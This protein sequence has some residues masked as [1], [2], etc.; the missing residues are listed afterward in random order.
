MLIRNFLKPKRIILGF[1]CI[2]LLTCCKNNSKMSDYNPLLEDFN[3][4]YQTVPFDKIKVEHYVPAFKVAM[5][6]GREDNKAIISN[7]EEP[8]FANRIEAL[9]NSGKL[10]TRNSSV[11]FNLNDAETSED[12]QKVAC[13]V[14]PI[15]PEHNN[16]LWLY[17]DLFLRLET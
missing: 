13:E 12:I 3:T 17:Y 5:E 15:L 8:S 7:T 10:L 4:P 11:F 9:E 14:S 6:H 2:A 1:G 16:D